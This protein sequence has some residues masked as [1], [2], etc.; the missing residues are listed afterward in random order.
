MKIL[1]SMLGAVMLAAAGTGLAAAGEHVERL[2]DG[3]VLLKLG[4]AYGNAVIETSVDELGP[5]LGGSTAAFPGATVRLL[6][7]DEGKHGP[8]SGPIEALRPVWE[9]LTGAK[10]ELGLVPVSELYATMA[11]ALARGGDR[12]DAAVV[13][14]YFYGDLIAGGHLTPVDG[15]LA[16]GRFPRWSYDSMPPSL[17]SLYQWGGVGYGV[18]NDADGQVLYYRRDVLTDPNNQ[19]AF[20]AAVGYDLPVPPRTWQQVLDIARFFAGK[21]WDAHDSQPDSGI[22]LHLKPGEQ[23][24]YHFTSLSASFA[25]APGAAVDRY[26]QV[27]WFD[28]QDMKPLINEPGHVAALELLEQLAATG[29]ADQIGWRLP[30][31]WEYFLRGKAVFMFTW[32]DLGALCQDETRSLVKGNCAVA[33]L[34]GSD[35]YWDREHGQWV[36]STE[37]NRVGNTTGGSWH[38]VLLAGSPNQEAAYSFLAL[39]AVKPFSLWAVQHG[40]TGINPGFAYQMLPPTGE[41]RL[42]D[43]L[44]A[45]WN[46]PDLEDYLTAFQQTFNAPTMLPYLR[47]RGTPAYW[48]ALD[49]QLAAA[50]G[51]RKTAQQ[52]LDD[53]AAAWDKITDRLGRDQQRDEYRKAIGYAPGPS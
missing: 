13:A 24:F 17:R 52:A 30:Q 23:G 33:M 14:A 29:P 49:S 5:L 1:G 31:A 16:S 9:E 10:L 28:P 11:L 48:S 46:R 22:V 27:Y 50:L 12:Y 6:T 37:P 45:G 39:M 2:D 21:N 36:E 4:P 19:A 32:G 44:K 38:G 34:P 20:K 35:R 40:W 42:A 3:T 47:I 25:V 41:A 43:Y 15:L 8:I 7:Q 26:H 53:T 51:G 18:R